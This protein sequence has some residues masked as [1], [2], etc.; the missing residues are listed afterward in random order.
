MSYD[1]N[2]QEVDLDKFPTAK[3]LVDRCKEFFAEVQNL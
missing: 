2:N 3:L 1:P